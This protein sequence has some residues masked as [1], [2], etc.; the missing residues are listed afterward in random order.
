MVSDPN[1]VMV[2]IDA[3]VVAHHRVAVRGSVGGEVIGEDFSVAPTLAGLGKLTGRLG[4]FPGALVVAEPTAMSWL[5]LGHA[6]NDADCGFALIETRHSSK[7]REAI[8]GKNKTDVIDADML[9]TSVELFGLSA[10]PLPTASQVAL[11]RAVRRRHRIT[12][13]A[14]NADVRL[15]ALAMWVFPDLWN[16]MDGSHRLARMVFSHWPRLDRL[17]RAHTRS[18]AALCR[19][20]LRDGGDP[21]QRAERIREAAR[22]WARFWTGR[23]DLDAVAWELSEMLGDLDALDDKLDRVDGQVSRLWRSRWGGDELL[24]SVSGI[25]PVTAPV[26]RAYLDD[27]RQFNTSK[28]AV[29]FVGLNPSNWESGLMASPSRPITKEGPPELRLAFYQAANVARRYDPQLAEFY[30]RMMCQRG[31]NHIQATCA[32]AR[33]LVC[34]VWATLT[35]GEP[36]EL[37]D[38]DGN[39]VDTAEA[40]RLVAGYAVPEHVRRRARARSKPR[41]GRL[42]G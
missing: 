32:V 42:S 10:G 4:E 41:R 39:P 30:Q 15:W 6:V 34:R 28:Q 38:V 2:G 21:T 31:H 22:G 26:I 11:R 13:D 5:A 9:A 35:S 37:R 17:A 23:L 3:A 1:R 12:A 16:A 29:A 33:K 19:S 25:G 7:L 14:H 40:R 24:V 27:C 36:Y 20:Y 18:V 8:A